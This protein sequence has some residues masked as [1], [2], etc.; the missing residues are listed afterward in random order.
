MVMMMLMRYMTVFML[1]FMMMFVLVLMLMVMMMFVFMLVA[2]HYSIAIAM[3]KAISW[4]WLACSSSK[5]TSKSQQST[6]AL[7]TLLILYSKPFAGI[8]CRALST[9]S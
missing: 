6:P 5:T 3:Q 1:V 9:S 4:S 2:M 8:L 7:D